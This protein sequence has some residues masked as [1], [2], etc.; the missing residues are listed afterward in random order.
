MPSVENYADGSSKVIGRHAGAQGIVTLARIL[1]RPS[2][3]ADSRPE[4]YADGSQRWWRY[5]APTEALN[6]AGFVGRSDLAEMLGYS[7]NMSFGGCA[8]RTTPD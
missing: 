6:S 1:D 2:Q 5:L 7:G 8:G 4:S 3:P